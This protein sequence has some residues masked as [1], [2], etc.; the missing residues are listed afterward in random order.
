MSL[1]SLHQDSAG[2][3]LGAGPIGGIAKTSV[4]RAK[5]ICAGEV[6]AVHQE[7]REMVSVAGLLIVGNW[8]VADFFIDHLIKGEVTSRK[9]RVR[10]FVPRDSMQGVYFLMPSPKESA[11]FFSLS[12]WQSENPP[13]FW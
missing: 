2:A 9:I 8:Q 5:V 10:F 11:A 4:E 6:Q 7:E 3:V 1:E 12:Q 13:M